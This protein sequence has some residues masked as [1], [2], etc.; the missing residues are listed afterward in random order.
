[1]T[2]S[3]ISLLLSAEYMRVPG[4]ID[5]FKKQTLNLVTCISGR[6][7][8]DLHEKSTCGTQAHLIAYPDYGN[9]VTC[10]LYMIVKKSAHLRKP[11]ATCLV[12]CM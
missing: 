4:V 9:Q 7:I 8:G 10:I 3:Q 5:S 11:T 2:S 1:M 6:E 12:K